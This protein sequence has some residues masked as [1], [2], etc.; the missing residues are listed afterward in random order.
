MIPKH[1]QDRVCRQGI[2]FIR[3]THVLE[4]GHKVLGNTLQVVWGM[5]KMFI[6]VI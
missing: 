2:S 1:R 5:L 3:Q 4:A 6:L